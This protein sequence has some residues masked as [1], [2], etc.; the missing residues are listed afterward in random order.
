MVVADGDRTVVVAEDVLEC[1][2]FKMK[3]YNSHFNF[4]WNKTTYKLG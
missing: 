3:G 1:L 2:E 4:G